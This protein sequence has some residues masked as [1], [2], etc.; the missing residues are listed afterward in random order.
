MNME[1]FSTVNHRLSIR[2]GLHV[3]ASLP[4]VYAIWLVSRTLDGDITAL[5]ADPEEEIM[6]F[7]GEWG[8]RGLLLTLAVSPA[9]RWLRWPV[10]PYR[11]MLGLWSFFYLVLHLLS[12]VGL[13]IE[14]DWMT[15]LE[16]VVERSFIYFGMAGFV[17]LLLLAVT[18]TRGWQLRLRRNWR[19]LH[20]LVYPAVILGLIH[21]FMQIRSD[22]TEF[23]LYALVVSIL[24]GVRVI[25]RRLR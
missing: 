19:R 13:V 3:L 22:Y 18:S 17:L 23:A 5:G 15:F 24:L 16:D 14:F 6:E 10:L 4:L 12:Y 8:L 25:P 20:R 7:W 1:R 11:R 21:Y 9:Q 2:I